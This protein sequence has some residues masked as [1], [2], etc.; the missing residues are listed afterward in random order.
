MCCFEVF[1]NYN[2]IN[3]YRIINNYIKLEIVFY[4]YENAY[5]CNINYNYDTNK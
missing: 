4:L 2:Y 5:I 1:N 3:L